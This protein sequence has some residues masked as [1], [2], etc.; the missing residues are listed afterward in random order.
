M[1]VPLVKKQLL[2]GVV[3]S[4]YLLGGGWATWVKRD[5]LLVIN[6]RDEVYNMGNIVNNTI[7]TLYGNG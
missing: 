1:K 6:H 4:R 7:I 5:K 3:R 2:G